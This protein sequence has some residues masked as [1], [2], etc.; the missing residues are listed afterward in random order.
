MTDSHRAQRTNGLQARLG[1]TVPDLLQRCDAVGVAVGVV[2]DGAVAFTVGFGLAD[3]VSGG[4]VTSAT[5]FNVGSISKVVTGWG[6]MRLVEAGQ[7][8]LEEPVASY[9]KRWQFNASHFDNCGVTVQRLMSHT[10]GLSMPSI[11][12]FEVPQPLPS[13]EEILS[14]AY[15]GSVYARPGS[16][17]E[18]V[19][20]PG[21]ECR[22][23]GG[24]TVLLQLLV[25]EVVS[26][27]FEDHMRVEVLEPLDMTSSRFGWD[28]TLV[29]Q[30]AVPYD[31]N[32]QAHPTYRFT[33]TSG[34]G[35]YSTATDMARFVAAGLS[36]PAGVQAGRDVLSSTTIRRMYVPVEL[37]DGQ[38]S[39]C[40]L[41]YFID[42]GSE[43]RPKTVSHGGSNCGWR[44]HFVA[45]PD[46]GHGLVILTNSD[47][48]DPL[49]K[50]I[51][52]LWEHTELGL[53]LP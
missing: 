19:C 42:P 34:A 49:L 14:G 21:S 26:D 30:A 9:L 25:E 20:Q 50:Q 44:A 3:K 2:R 32:G 51:I 39:P 29:A 11:P 53:P 10:A 6:V 22:Y 23:S 4:A 5:V 13:L 35:L 36:S 45:V 27:S 16:P 8:V 47:N 48:A 46:S 17:V 1:A 7:L 41:A 43:D 15:Q 38:S 18:L 40:G 24:G 28:E 37:N 12:G 52:C 33:G 31:S